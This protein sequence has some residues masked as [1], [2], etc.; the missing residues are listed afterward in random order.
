[1]EVLFSDLQSTVLHRSAKPPILS[2]FGDIALA[3][4][5]GFTPYLE[6]T[7]QVLQQA[8]SMRA[9]P[10]RH[11]HH[12]FD[13]CQWLIIVSQDNMELVDYV[14]TLREAILEAYTGIVGAFKQAHKSAYH[15]PRLSLSRRLTLLSSQPRSY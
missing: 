11:H 15:G 3:V 6:T 4:G 2:C 1:M 9:D 14:L 7:M 5:E 8:G 13:F 12:H 10:V